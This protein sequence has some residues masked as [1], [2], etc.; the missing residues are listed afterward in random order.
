MHMQ[1][2]NML[3]PLNIVMN[4]RRGLLFKLTRLIDISPSHICPVSTL[5][6]INNIANISIHNKLQ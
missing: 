5:Q 4:G 1:V 3:D 6:A 2:K